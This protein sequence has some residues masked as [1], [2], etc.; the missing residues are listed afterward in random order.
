MQLALAASKSFQLSSKSSSSEEGLTSRPRPVRLANRELN[1][2]P[3][4]KKTGD[5]GDHQGASK[6]PLDERSGPSRYHR[7]APT[8]IAWPGRAPSEA[9]HALIAP[10]CVS[11]SLRGTKRTSGPSYWLPAI[12]RPRRAQGSPG[13]KPAI[14]PTHF[15][16]SRPWRSI[17][18]FRT[19][20][21]LE[22]RLSTCYRFAGRGLRMRN[23]IST[24]DGVSMGAPPS[25]LRRLRPN[26][27]TTKLLRA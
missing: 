15:E 6:V 20:S 4:P 24:Y 23:R 16:N 1:L 7:L 22:S 14:R 26:R 5:R 8:L 17:S 25:H 3:R 21:S 27:P 12:A 11:G 9:A 13:L 10:A 19:S 2:P 18:R